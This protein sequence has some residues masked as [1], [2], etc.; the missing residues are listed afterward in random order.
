MW[1]CRFAK[2]LF[3]TLIGFIA[4]REFHMQFLIKMGMDEKSAEELAGNSQGGAEDEENYDN[5]NN[6]FQLES[7]G[8]LKRSNSV[9]LR[10][11][12]EITTD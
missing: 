7:E 4:W 9:L 1:V 10:L 11:W 6:S 8:Q 12:S 3:C 2:L 5:I